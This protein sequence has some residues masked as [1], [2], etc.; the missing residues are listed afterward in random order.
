MQECD[1]RLGLDYLLSGQPEREV[2]IPPGKDYRRG[3]LK[4]LSDLAS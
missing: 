3:V 4:R 2:L 1:G